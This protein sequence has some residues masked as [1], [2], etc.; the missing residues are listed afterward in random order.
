ME[1]QYWEGKEYS[2]LVTKTANFFRATRVRNR[3]ILIV[4]SAI[5]LC[6]HSEKNA[7]ATSVLQKKESRIVRI[8]GSPI[9]G[10]I[11]DM[12]WANMRSLR[13]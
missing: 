1:K 2:F 13:N 4:C 12:W 8:A 10:K 9:N 6:M 5:A 11:T 3:R 7:V